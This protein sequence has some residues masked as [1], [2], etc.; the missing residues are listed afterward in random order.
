MRLPIKTASSLTSVCLFTI[1]AG[2]AIAEDAFRFDDHLPEYLS[3]S[4]ETRMRYETLDGQF[5][6]GGT[7][8]DQMLL[9]RTLVHTK[10]DTGPIT[11]G[12]ELQDSRTYLDDDGTPNS[13]SITN[14]LDILQL[15]AQF[16]TFGLLGS[17]SKTNVKIGRQTVSIGS[18][19]QIERVSFANVI[20]AYTG[21]HALSKNDRGD[22][23]H[24]AYV[25]PIDRNPADR[26]NDLDDNSLSGD[27]EEWD[28]RIWAI[29]YRRANFIPSIAEDIWG[30]VFVYGLN[31]EDNSTT[32]TPNRDYI[33]PGFRLYRKPKTKQWDM[34]V[35]GVWRT[36]SRR[37]TSLP[38]D[39]TDLDVDAQMLF[40]AVGYTFNAPWQPR[41]ALEYY[42]ASGDEDPS[43]NKFDQYE[44]LFG[45]RRTDLNNTSIH[46][47]LTPA[48]LSAPGARIQVK[49][50]DRWDARLA[51]SAAFL[52]SDT[53]AWVIAKQRDATG[54][55]GDFIGH[56]LDGRARYW[57]IPDSLRF[58][59]GASVFLK[60]DFAKNAPNASDEDE[61]FFGYT[62]FIFSF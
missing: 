49:P 32:A 34:D 25:V 22:E 53:D 27:S 14:P 39:T 40:S 23:L 57:V 1:F 41:L 54:Q 5:R 4:G 7:G 9:F 52:A 18:K 6:A 43:D 16:D 59:M 11:F 44:R 46:G 42:Y 29:H 24:F 21:V 50:N 20:K 56:T 58:D 8:S 12:L 38:T 31:E 36:G 3:I 13:S 28:R 62:A 37:A 19:R 26:I 17:D 45:S 33:G 60:G 48:N 35:E 15:Y 47:P 51:Y 2:N 61:T 30:E 10:L 55:S